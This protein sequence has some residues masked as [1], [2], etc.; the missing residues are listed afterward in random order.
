MQAAQAT[1][2]ARAEELRDVVS[3]ARAH[4]C[5]TLRQLAAHLNG[6]GVLTPRGGTWAAA[7]AA[8][9]LYQLDAPVQ[10]RVRA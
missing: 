8:R 5:T 9:L 10:A 2:K 4:G 1:A 3:D 6:L 7:S